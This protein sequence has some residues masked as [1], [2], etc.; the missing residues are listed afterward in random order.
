MP[1]FKAGV[2]LTTD[3][4]GVVKQIALTKKNLE[5]LNEEMELGADLSK[6]YTSSTK[7][8]AKATKGLNA[9][10][11]TLNK[12]FAALNPTV[13]AATTRLTF[14]G[15]ALPKAAIGI[16]A[17][18]VGAGAATVSLTKFNDQLIAMQNRLRPVTD[19][20]GNMNAVFNRLVEMSVKS[21]TA[22]EANVTMFSRAALATESLGI[23]QQK[24]IDLTE[25]LAIGLRIGG[26]SAQESAGA[27][28]QFTQGLALGRFETQEL[29]SVL[30]QSVPI[31]RALQTE[32]RKNQGELLKMAE[33]GELAADRVV[34]ALTGPALAE[35]REQLKELPV[36]ATEGFTQLREAS[37]LL[38]G[39][40]ADGA[41]ISV[42]LGNAMRDLALI[43]I[44]VRESVFMAG[45]ATKEFFVDL[46]SVLNFLGRILPDIAGIVTGQVPIWDLMH[47]SVGALDGLLV[48]LAAS[49]EA[50]Q[51]KIA[52]F[53]TEL[54]D[55]GE[56]ANFVMRRLSKEQKSFIDR[57]NASVISLDNYNAELARVK[58]AKP[59][60]SAEAYAKALADLKRKYEE[61]IPGAKE[62]REETERQAKATDAAEKAYKKYID[63][64]KSAGTPQE[65]YN[66]ELKKAQDALSKNNI[67]LR[68]YTLELQ[69]LRQKYRELFPEETRRQELQEKAKELISS[70][71]TEQ[72]LFNQKL[73]LYTTLLEKNLLN[74]EQFN[75]LRKRALDELTGANKEAAETSAGFWET[76]ADDVT[77]AFEDTFIRA[78]SSLKDFIGRVK[79]ALK[80]A[81]LRRIFQSVL[82]AFG[83]GG[84][85]NAFAGILGGAGGGGGGSAGGGGILS[86]LGQ[87]GGAMNFL[88]GGIGGALSSIGGMYGS[89]TYGATN[90]VGNLLGASSPIAQGFGNAMGNLYVGNHAIG[91]AL[92]LQGNAA[93][94]AGGL[95][96]AGAGIAGGYLG[97]RFG[98]K[99]FNKQ[100]NSSWG[101]TAGG[102]GGA[103]IGA[104]FGSMGGPIGALIGAA[105]GAM[106]DVLGGGDGKKR[107]NIGTL[108]GAGARSGGRYGE[109][110]TGESG[111]TF[112][113]YNRRG[114]KSAANDFTQALVGIDSALTQFARAAGIDVDF[115]G[116]TGW[117][118]AP[119]AGHGGSGPFFGLKGYNGVSGSLEDQ[120]IS[121]IDTF[122]GEI[123]DQL[124]ERVK[125]LSAA[126]TGTAGELVDAFGAALNIDTLLGLDVV[127]ETNDALIELEQAQK[128]I[129]EQY[130]ELS[131][132]TLDAAENF[133]G[134]AVALV[135][136][137]EHLIAQKNA[138]VQLA[139]AYQDVGSQLDTL[140]SDT[141]SSIQES[142]MTDEEIYALR[143][144]EIN[145]LNAQL[146]QAVS[147]EEID[148]LTRAIDS[149]TRDAF[150][151][152]DESQK[153]ILAN[154]F[155]DFLTGVRSTAAARVEAGQDAINSS[156]TAIRNAVDVQ[157][158]GVDTFENAVNTFAGAVENNAGGGGG[159]EGGGVPGQMDVTQWIG[160]EVRVEVGM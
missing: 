146:S 82:G 41:D 70:L 141:I 131:K 23:S 156:D 26:A 55:G 111:L 152:L 122:I 75:E 51:A 49:A 77:N 4:Q 142:I 16:G 90:L 11:A 66:R 37:G 83:L 54:A 2:I 117:G 109:H 5:A 21:R 39:T 110:I 44:D 94:G 100:A 50:S 79:D 132:A 17:L 14:L 19:S 9:E 22:L 74:E 13:G 76:F 121:F 108:V 159:G 68:E 151:L 48:D 81:G 85:S 32:F 65:N 18:V 116:K 123:S 125:K 148:R 24:L 144:Q 33:A 127:N 87:A 99:I 36:S 56:Q 153:Q 102:I 15:A 106:V 89:F 107:V 93:V 42:T 145:D 10:T 118:V 29:K 46:G 63:R 120:A 60:L 104:K 91:N 128:T 53:Q 1:K 155:I 119:D 92:G 40:F 34:K 59:H 115:S 86:Q 134:S 84:G 96:T 143:R 12:I 129:L 126:V 130:E 28:V 105:I 88:K 150:S 149:A 98:E 27:I 8:Q 114:D 101:S 52:A 64:L 95:V 25:S 31:A 43:M 3:D 45:V 160:D 154:D 97:N 6:K 72:D 137:N 139:L 112:Q 157:L 124:P 30:E 69:R 71:A 67:G 62:A 73:A 138:A 135:E 35:F 61:V 133:D 113:S 140:L 78:E 147:P 58:E 47:N 136:L 7:R 103:M 57:L 158:Q 38:V 80:E 20:T